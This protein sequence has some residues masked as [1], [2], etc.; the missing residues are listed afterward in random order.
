MSDSAISPISIVPSA[1]VPQ[2]AINAAPSLN[3][4]FIV[5]TYRDFELQPARPLAQTIDE[6]I[7]FHLVERSNLS[8][9]PRAAVAEAMGPERTRAAPRGSEPYLFLNGR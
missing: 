3:L 5:G 4:R 8:G 9:L 1:D 2:V 6:L 7:R